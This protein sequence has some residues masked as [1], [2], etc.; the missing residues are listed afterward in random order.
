M[1]NKD[2][3]A[4]LLL[5]VLFLV[6]F[7]SAEVCVCMYIYVALVIISYMHYNAYLVGV[8]SVAHITCFVS[9]LALPCTDLSEL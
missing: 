2:K 3:V 8:P 7:V 4:A 5:C 9:L 1:A 6:A